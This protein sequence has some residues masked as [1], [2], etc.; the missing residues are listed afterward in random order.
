MV[1][2]FDVLKIEI[3]SCEN[4]CTTQIKCTVILFITT[5]KNIGRNTL[6]LTHLDHDSNS[7]HRNQQ[8]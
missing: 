3:E 2:E 6:I 1:L 5:F 8:S 7:L 4:N